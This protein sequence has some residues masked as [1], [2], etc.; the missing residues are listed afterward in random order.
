[1]LDTYRFFSGAEP[2][3]F[4]SA[5]DDDGHGTHT[6]LTAAGNADVEASIFGIPRG[7]VSGIAPRARVTAYKGLGELGGF[8]SDLAAAIDQAVADG[9]LGPSPTPAM[10]G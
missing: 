7:T 6:A 1:M 2:E 3:E 10:L 5:R 9:T 8:G 4:D